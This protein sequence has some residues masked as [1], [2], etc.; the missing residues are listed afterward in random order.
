MVA[1]V[2]RARARI[3]D[4][5]PDLELGSRPPREVE[6]PKDQAREHEQQ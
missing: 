4:S 1:G 6:E 2:D 5:S 3:T